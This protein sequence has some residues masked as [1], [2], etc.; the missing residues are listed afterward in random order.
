MSRNLLLEAK[1]TRVPPKEGA[2][3]LLVVSGEIYDSLRA[4]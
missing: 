1:K 3:P 2:I 4:L